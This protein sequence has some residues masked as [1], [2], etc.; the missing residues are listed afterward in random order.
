MVSGRIDRSEDFSFF[1]LCVSSTTNCERERAR[2]QERERVP[3]FFRK[4]KRRRKKVRHTR[5]LMDDRRDNNE[6]KLRDANGKS[7]YISKTFA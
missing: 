6:K 7:I 1:A 3:S 5:H 4:N 2:A